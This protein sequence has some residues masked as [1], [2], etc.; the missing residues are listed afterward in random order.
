[1]IDFIEW[2]EK[3]LLLD[4]YI[5]QLMKWQLV[6]TTT[7]TIT[8]TTI[9]ITTSTSPATTNWQIKCTKRNVHQQFNHWMNTCLRESMSGVDLIHWPKYMDIMTLTTYLI[10]MTFLLHPIIPLKVLKFSLMSF[11]YFKLQMDSRCHEVNI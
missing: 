3:K 2:G 4:S 5:S 7:T 6:T 1:M 11:I 9:T 10:S 8:I